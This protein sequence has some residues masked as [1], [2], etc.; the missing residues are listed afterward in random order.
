MNYDLLLIKNE[1]ELFINQVRSIINTDKYNKKRIID[2]N[3]VKFCEE[4]KEDSNI[5][6]LIGIMYLTEYNKTFNKRKAVKMFIKSSKQNNKYAYNELGIFYQIYEITDRKQKAKIFFKKSIEL[7]CLDAMCNL[8][9]MYIE[10]KKYDKAKKLLDL[11]LEKEYIEAYTSIAELYFNGYFG[12]KNTET[13]LEY[14]CKAYNNKYITEREKSYI[15][16]TICNYIWKEPQVIMEIYKKYEKL[17]MD[18]IE[19]ESRPPT[20]G[21]KIYEQAKNDFE[22]IFKNI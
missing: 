5:Q 1:D 4:N 7:S 16:N 17:K 8:S 19:L 11:C 6:C 13:A 21:G 3:L 2:N 22:N 9:W 14:L 10:E 20:Q 12:K 18:I 15:N